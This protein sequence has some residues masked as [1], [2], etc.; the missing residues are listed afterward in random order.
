MNLSAR[1]WQMQQ[2]QDKWCDHRLKPVT[3]MKIRAKYTA[4]RSMS[5]VAHIPVKQALLVACCLPFGCRDVVTDSE[6]IKACLRFCSVLELS[7]GCNYAYMCHALKEVKGFHVRT[8]KVWKLTAAFSMTE[9]PS[10]GS[11]GFITSNLSLVVEYIGTRVIL[12]CLFVTGA[13]SIF[14]WTAP[15]K[16]HHV[17]LIKWLT[18]HLHSITKQTF[19]LSELHVWCIFL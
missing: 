8:W 2:Q 5:V 9:K 12:V 16:V 3:S 4:S 15:N 13:S 17:G 11:F 19:W 14:P 1:K 18:P 7:L 10:R 6:V